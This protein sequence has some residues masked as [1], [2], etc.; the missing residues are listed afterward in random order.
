MLWIG[1]LLLVVLAT[2][3][4]L[5]GSHIESPRQAAAT[6]APPPPAVLTALVVR[7]VLSNT[8]V[9]R[10]NVVA[11]NATPVEMPTLPGGSQPVVTAVEKKAGN[12][13]NEGD[14]LFAVADRPVIVLRG[15]IPAFRTMTPGDVGTDVTELQQALHRLG[16][17]TGTDAEGHYGYGTEQAVRD[18]YAARGFRVELTSPQADINLE[19]AQQAVTAAQRALGTPGGNTP[20]ATNTL[21]QAQA[22]LQN[23][24]NTTGAIVPLGEVVFV[25]TLPAKVTSVSISAGQLLQEGAATAGASSPS[26]VSP[27][28]AAVAGGGASSSSS[29]APMMLGSGLAELDGQVPTSSG[30][31][32]RAGMPATAIDDAT[33]QRWEVVVTKVSVPSAG[34]QA[35]GSNSLQSTV[36]LRAG[37]GAAIPLTEIGNN[38]RVRVS[39]ASTSAPV[40]VVP[41]AAIYSHANG[42]SYVSVIDG[43]SQR[44]VP[45]VTGIDV[46]GNIQVTPVGAQLHPGNRV[47][48]GSSG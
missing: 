4:G 27:S 18:F 12:S 10:A 37:S 31:L 14:V 7:K 13:I 43:K 46:G 35:V 2:A 15:A 28:A 45:V 41:I 21:A 6:A 20:S 16:Y 40:L 1:G 36:I 19:N 11:A 9:F 30:S 39:T 17:S 23:L 33:G 48:I 34:N 44:V 5:F 29:S 25:P 8:L 32:L 24:E 3:A 42:R 26:G 22:T 47:L 38:L